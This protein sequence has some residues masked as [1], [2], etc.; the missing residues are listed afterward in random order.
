MNAQELPAHGLWPHVSID[1]AV[2]ILMSFG[3]NK[4]RTAR[5]WRTFSALCGFLVALF[6]ELRDFGLTIYLPYG[7]FARTMYFQLARH[8][9]RKALAAIG[10]T[11]SRYA[12]ATPALAPRWLQTFAGVAQ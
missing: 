9:E 10:E 4:S 12:A 5:D 11:C 2:S 8:E 6:T 1:G 3:F 7:W